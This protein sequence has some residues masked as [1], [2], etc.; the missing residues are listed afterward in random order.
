M[1]R[2]PRKLL[3]LLLKLIVSVIIF[4]AIFVP[5]SVPIF[6]MGLLGIALLIQTIAIVL[7]FIGLPQKATL[8]RYW[9]SKIL[10]PIWSQLILFLRRYHLQN[11]IIGVH[12]Y[13]DA[14]NFYFTEENSK[15]VFPQ[16]WIDGF[17][18]RKITQILFTTSAVTTTAST[19][20]FITKIHKNNVRLFINSL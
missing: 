9:R 16:Q 2:L 19:F 15:T 13:I 11:M 6:G 3:R 12:M 18:N 7:D 8:T 4:I 20:F 1:Q 17:F 5:F 10:A 14:V